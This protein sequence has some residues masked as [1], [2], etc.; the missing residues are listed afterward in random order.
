MFG[1]P[2]IAIVQQADRFELARCHCAECLM[3]D[4]RYA[5]QGFQLTFFPMGA[6]ER[7]QADALDRKR[8]RPS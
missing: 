3:L 7:W 6:I 5:G 2:R 4:R 8:G 1:Q